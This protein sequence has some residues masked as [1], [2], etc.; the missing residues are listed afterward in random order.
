MNK[1][2]KMDNIN[3][4]QGELKQLVIDTSVGEKEDIKIGTPILLARVYNIELYR[5]NINNHLLL[6]FRN[7]MNGMKVINKDSTLIRDLYNSVSGS[8]CMGRISKEMIERLCCDEENMK[9]YFNIRERKII[10]VIQSTKIMNKKMRMIHAKR[11]LRS[12]ATVECDFVEILHPITFKG[13]ILKIYNDYEKGDA[14]KYIF[15]PWDSVSPIENNYFFEG[16]NIGS[17]GLGM[18][19]RKVC[20]D[21]CVLCD[22]SMY[23]KHYNK[24]TFIE[25]INGEEAETGGNETTKSTDNESRCMEDLGICD[26]LTVLINGDEVKKDC[27]GKHGCLMGVARCDFD[28]IGDIYVCKNGK[29]YECYVINKKHMSSISN[30]EHQ[31]PWVKK[32]NTKE[33][34]TFNGKIV[35]SSK[36]INKTIN[37][38]NTPQRYLGRK[39]MKTRRR[40]VGQKGIKGSKGMMNMDYKV[41]SLNSKRNITKKTSI[42]TSYER[43][44]IG[45]II[46]IHDIRNRSNRTHPFMIKGNLSG[47]RMNEVKLGDIKGTSVYDT[48]MGFRIWTAIDKKDNTSMNMERMSLYDLWNGLLEKGVMPS[49]DLTSQVYG[50]C[51]GRQERMK[52][53]KFERDKGNKIVEEKECEGVIINEGG[54]GNENT[55]TGSSDVIV[56]STPHKSTDSKEVKV[57]Q[58]QGTKVIEGER[59]RDLK[60]SDIIKK[61]GNDVSSMEGVLKEIRNVIFD[62]K[63]SIRKRKR[64]G[65]DTDKK[66]DLEITS[67][68]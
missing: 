35:T 38:S 45:L 13:V 54:G 25:F 46:S 59:V 23:K 67:F 6:S 10:T 40:F 60:N 68:F 58:K 57:K 5:Y 52:S 51:I 39:G 63:K 7:K 42:I 47:I 62:T 24:Q 11:I 27:K 9:F 50:N 44:V 56:T 3:N 18:G 64:G 29:G 21:G 49:R 43:W 14:D 17:D 1:M 48:G 22:V 65:Q 15:V 16:Q 61:I 33:V 26:D 19:C 8:L 41:V 31:F 4:I 36:T 32:I 37:K 66:F 2:S 30:G 34:E 12:L 20:K 55:G 53:A 28:N